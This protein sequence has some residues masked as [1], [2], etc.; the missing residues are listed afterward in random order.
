VQNSHLYFEK[1]TVKTQ[2]Q[3][4]LNI[5]LMGA[6]GAV[7]G[8][9]LRNLMLDKRA[10]QITLI[11]R[12]ELGLTL[13]GNVSQAVVDIENP[14]DYSSFITGN[15][16]AICCLGVG[17]PSKVS[18]EEF[19]RIDYTAVLNFAKASKESGVKHF[20]LLSAVGANASTGYY[21]LRS[22]GQLQDD[23]AALGFD[24]VSFFQ[25]SMILTPTNR[26]DFLQGVMLA[27]WPAISKVLVGSLSKFRGIEA[28][29]LGKA[30]AINSFTSFKGVKVLQWKEIVALS[31]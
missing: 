9:V 14:R 22:K 1:D 19:K 2:I 27:T 18:Q 25:P 23:I 7:G 26:Y 11:N 28:D 12:R 31:I 6:S 8:A 29:R 5:V 17:Q 30:I 24:S 21:Y 15:E 13:P 16:C 3:I 4:P 20:Q 10:A